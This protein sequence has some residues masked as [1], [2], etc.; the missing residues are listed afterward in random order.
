MEILSETTV[1]NLKGRINQWGN[2][3]E[4]APNNVI[5]VGRRFTMGGWNLP[6][7]EFANPFAINKSLSREQAISQ[8]KD[9]I[10]DKL[11]KD[12]QFKER[13][14][15]CKNKILACWCCPEACHSDVLREILDGKVLGKVV[16]GAKPGRGKGAYPIVYSA[17]GSEYINIPA[18]SRGAGIWKTL[19]PFTLKPEIF[20][21]INFDGSVTERDVTCIENLWQFSKIEEKL[22]NEKEG[23]PPKDEW[24]ARRNNGWNDPE[25]HR[26][27][28]VKADRTHPSLGRHYWNGKYISYEEARKEIYIPF[29]WKSAIQTPAFKQLV[30]MR[31][32]GVNFQIIGPDG[33]N[34]E[35]GLKGELAD[36]MKPFG[37]ELVLVAMLTMNS[38]DELLI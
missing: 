31:E 24:F 33:R 5:Y 32:R 4:K 36:I 28:L 2:K 15:A 35:L 3:L 10:N 1:I 17:N 37:H 27:V 23:L 30:D 34:I 7:S 14:F 8:Y 11:I 38:I 13:L 21:E 22:S 16:C 25:P 26:H 29:Y 9:Y 19:S 18:Y 12:S 6:E 20:T